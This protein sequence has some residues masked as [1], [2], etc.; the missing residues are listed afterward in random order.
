MDTKRSSRLNF[1]KL[2]DKT[3]GSSIPIN[4]KSLSTNKTSNFLLKAFNRGTMVE[5]NPA[6]PKDDHD[7]FDIGQLSLKDIDIMEPENQLK[8]DRRSIPKYFWERV[9]NTHS[10]LGVL[11]K[12]TILVPFWTRVLKVIFSCANTFLFGA[13]FFT[14]NYIK[15]REIRLKNVGSDFSYTLVHEFSKSFIAAF[16]AVILST[17]A[18]TLMAPTKIHA[19]NVMKALNT[20][21]I[22]II[23]MENQNVL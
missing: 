8:Y 9:C 4:G 16:F 15:G 22:A 6:Y 2:K 23:D 20:K 13:I 12:K 5:V 3:S 1:L 21:D 10:L 7:E 11:V 18:N 19:V 14:D 17:S